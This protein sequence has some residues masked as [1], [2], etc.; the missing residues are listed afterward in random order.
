MKTEPRES[1]FHHPTFRYHLKACRA[2]RAFDDFQIDAIALAQRS[3]PF[4]DSAVIDAVGPDLSQFGKPLRQRPQNCL[5]AVAILR[6]RRVNFDQ[7][8]QAKRIDQEMPFP[9]VDSL[10]RVITALGAA[11]IRGLDALAIEDGGCR[12]QRTPFSLSHEV[13]QSCGDSRPAAGDPPGAKIAVDGF[14]GRILAR[15]MTPLAA[16]PVEIKDRIES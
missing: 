13:A 7:Q 12:L 16:R 15:Q 14:P 8:R 1:S 9:P 2:F 10:A 4:A 5:G 3:D 6:A 11:T